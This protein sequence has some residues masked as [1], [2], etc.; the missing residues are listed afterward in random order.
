MLAIPTLL[1]SVIC[2]VWL[3][4]RESRHFPVLS[5]A[6]WIPTALVLILGSRPLSHWIEGSGASGAGSGGSPW[7]EG[8]YALILGTSFFVATSRGVKWGRF[9]GA[10]FPLML[11]YVFFA[12]SVLWS[13]DPL[14]SA[15]R[16]VKDFGLFFVL[17]V[18]FSEEDPFRSARA[19]FI[20][21]ACI[22][23][24]LSI[25][26]NRYFPDI[27]RQFALD[28][29]MML[30]GL[31]EQKNSL[32]E[33]ILVF[34]SML[35]WELL[36]RQRRTGYSI[37]RVMAVEDVV[38]FAMGGILL[39]QSQSKTALLCFAICVGVTFRPVA[40]RS[41]TASRLLFLG[42]LST[43]FL[44]FFSQVFGDAI[45]PIV[46]ALGRDMT[47]TGRTNI[48]VNINLKTV[49]PIFGNGYW[50]FWGGPG[51][52]AISDMIQ[53]NIPNAHCGYLDLYLDGGFSVLLLLGFMLIAYGFRLVAR[54][55]LQPERRLRM[56]FFCA[57][58]VYNL[59]E[60]SFFRIGLL[61]FT[62]LLVI[63][64]F[65]QRFSRPK[66]DRSSSAGKIQREEQGAVLVAAGSKLI[67]Q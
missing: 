13:G 67:T 27:S 33:T 53:W 16:I 17:A 66:R 49:N 62:T 54:Q 64:D 32:G 18:L 4:R 60:S 28:G 47:F 3:F 34:C 48:W 15:K 10:N 44:M 26:C 6:L 5:K 29:S 55:S 11:V 8:F 30:S 22:L 65:P 45:Q 41:R 38:L 23:F 25:A 40:F 59:S 9:F 7:D 12:C 31:T 2:A 39:A 46:Q 43:P 52:R 1:L 19:V 36:E 61:W 50:N 57:A 37:W 24:P 58:L 51:G 21:C 63:V 56:A 14:A 42:F 20:R 35:V